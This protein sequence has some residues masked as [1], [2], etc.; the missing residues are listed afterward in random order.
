ME[1]AV[2]AL[3]TGC[4]I[5]PVVRFGNQNLI[6]GNKLLHYRYHVKNCFK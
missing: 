3:P 2:T 5:N 6:S 1:A 4:S